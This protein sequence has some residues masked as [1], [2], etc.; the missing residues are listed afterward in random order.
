MRIGIIAPPWFAVPP[1][2]YGGIEWVVSHLAD[3]LAA[4]GHDVTLFASGGSR[5]RG[6]VVSVYERPPS[7]ELGDAVV[8]AVHISRAY[9]SWQ[10]FDIVHDHTV[11]GLMVGSMLNTPLVHTVHGQVLPKYGRF[12]AEV[13]DRVHFVTISDNQAS[14][15]PERCVTTTIYNGVDPALYPP[16]EKRGDHLLFVGRMSHEKGI[17]PAIEVARRTG[18]KLLILAK[19]NEAYEQ[20]Y[21]ESEVLPALAHVDAEV[22]LQVPHEE[23]AQAY[24]EAYATL[25]PI[26]WPEPFG[27]VMTE[28]MAAGTPVIAFRN[29][30][31]PEVIADGKTGFVCASVDEAVAAVAR[32]PEIDREACRRHVEEH[33]SAARNVELHEQLYQSLLE[34]R[35]AATGLVPIAPAHPALTLPSGVP[36]IQ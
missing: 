12:Y 6:R 9:E 29:G 33:F 3:G 5:S 31:V 10:Q 11:L 1:V 34:G 27:L 21:Y 32:V 28:S 7:A 20:E 23:K 22:R 26:Q 19:V 36:A 30:S 4:R 15:M 8:E 2:G 24:A 35:M 18:R 13:S 14:T 16:A 17:L 25:F